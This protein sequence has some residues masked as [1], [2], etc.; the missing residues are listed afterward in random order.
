MK[1]PTVEGGSQG[2]GD[3]AKQQVIEKGKE[4]NAE[5]I[6]SEDAETRVQNVKVL[7]FWLCD[8]GPEKRGNQPYTFKVKEAVRGLGLNPA[9]VIVL[10]SLA[11]HLTRSASLHPRV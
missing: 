9:W 4:E 8:F 3:E 5:Q 2:T 10:C 7:N 6:P 11:K 1:Q